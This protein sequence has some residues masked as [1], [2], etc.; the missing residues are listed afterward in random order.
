MLAEPK[1]LSKIWPLFDPATKG[2]AL[3]ERRTWSGKSGRRLDPFK[4][5]GSLTQ[6]NPAVTDPQPP[7]RLPARS[8]PLSARRAPSQ[9]RSPRPSPERFVAGAQETFSFGAKQIRRSS[10]KSESD[11]ILESDGGRRLWWEMAIS[12]TKEGT[13]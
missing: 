1:G 7:G 13:F 4:K 10:K 6:P 3:R 5:P 8:C 11:E 12:D 2:A 9:C